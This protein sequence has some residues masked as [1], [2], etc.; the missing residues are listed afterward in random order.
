MSLCWSCCRYGFSLL[1]VCRSNRLRDSSGL[2]GNGGLG[3]NGS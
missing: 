3:G 1:N 2:R